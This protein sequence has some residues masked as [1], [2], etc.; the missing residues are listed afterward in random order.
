MEKEEKTEDNVLLTEPVFRVKRGLF[1][2][3]IEIR[4]Y[5]CPECQS[6]LVPEVKIMSGT[7]GDKRMVLK[8]VKCGYEKEVL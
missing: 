3:E 1:S 7:I 4:G 5:H 2:S 6:E 8:C